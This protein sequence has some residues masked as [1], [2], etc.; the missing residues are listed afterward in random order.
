MARSL[1]HSV[2]AFGQD[3]MFGCYG[4]CATAAGTAAKV[5]TCA[6]FTSDM[7]I[8]G[9]QINIKF[10]KGNSVATGQITLNINSTGAKN[11]YC[12]GGAV[13]LFAN[14]GEIIPFVYDG[15]NWIAMRILHTGNLGAA[16]YESVAT[17]A[18]ANTLAKRQASGYLYATYF[19]QSSNDET[20]TTS[21]KFMY[22]NDDG[23][24]RKGT[25]ASAKT[26]LGLGSAASKNVQYGTISMG[27][28]A[29]VDVTFATAFSAVPYVVASYYTTG[30]QPSGAFGTLKLSTVTKNGFKIMQQG[31]SGIT[32]TACW[33]AM[34]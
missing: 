22:T 11:A 29:Y 3:I 12:D 14:T 17:A 1:V 18:T 32:V 4:T 13:N 28:G 26:A 20:M 33:I 15:T 6:G 27:S 10:T 16:A 31:T 9:C 34:L 19:N 7:L 30:S 25:I 2:S 8:A 24:L 21:S 23:F 5:V